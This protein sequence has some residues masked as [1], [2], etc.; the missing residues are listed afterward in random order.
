MESGQPSLQKSHR[1]IFTGDI[2]FPKDGGH[3]SFTVRYRTEPNTQW[4]WVNEQFG[5]RDGELVFEPPQREIERCL[6]MKE[7]ASQLAQFISD[8]NPDLRV[9]SCTSESPGAVVWKVTG[10]V[11]PVAANKSSIKNVALGKP[12]EFVRNFSLV[13]IWNPWL[14]PRHGGATYRLT[15]DALLSSFLLKDGKHLVI[16]AISINDVLTL[17]QSGG[18]NDIVISAKNDSKAE[19]SFQI[20]AS[21]A[22]SFDVGNAAV[23]YEARRVVSQFAHPASQGNSESSAPSSPLGNDIVVVEDIPKAQWLSNWYDGLAYCTWNSLG[24]DLSEEKLLNALDTLKKNGIKIVNLIID[25]NWQSLDNKGQSQFKRGWTGFEA[26]KEGFPNGLKHAIEKI[27]KNHANIEHIAVWHALLGYWGGI[28]PD[29]QIAKDY[30]TKRVKKVDG[31]AG[32]TMTAI[33]PDDIHRFYDDFYSFL[34]SAGIDSVKADAQFFLD[35][36]EDPEDRVRFTAA[37]QDAWTIS[38][39]RHFQTKAISCMSQAP[40]I[41]F[42]SQIP[43]NKPQILLRNSDDFF[44]DIPSSHPWHIFCNAHNALFTQHL[45]VLPDWDMFQTSHPYASF[46]GAARCISGG[47]VYITDEPGK[48]DIDLINQMTAPTVKGNSIILRPSVVGRAMNMYHNYNEGQMLK[49]GSFNGWARTGSGI[50]GLF[51]IN[52]S[53]VSSLIP[54]IDFPGISAGTGDEYVVR[55]HKTGKVSRNLDSSAGDSLI[56][57]FLATKGWEI[58]TAYPLRSF[59]LAGSHGIDYGETNSLTRVAVLGLL[60]KMTGVAA[61]TSSDIFVKDNGR[62]QFDISL[63]ALG[64]LG[65][66][67]SDLDERSIE[68]NFLVTILGSVVPFH[69]VRKASNAIEAGAPAGL[70]EIDILAAWSEMGL[71]SGWSNE[72]VVQVFMS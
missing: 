44:P 19:Q 7:H 25:D 62:L 36:L 13:R 59:T 33:D 69:T 37:Y 38:T 57:I 4:Q 58:L 55:S 21:V 3:Y 66:Y 41:I 16:L 28:S 2:K 24:Q 9:D 71:D 47:P 46:H 14:A 31:V 6:E 53:D 30:K 54:L 52:T 51:N 49:V 22:S 35:L 10:Q 15:E 60:G 72:V 65:I 8:L 5:T 29:G 34:L 1:Y 68:N 43:T 56:S 64:V 26:N 32:G 27:R 50:L 23:I 42:H 39:L 61:I 40:Q 17:L 11:G 70:L 48:H 18:N 20:I 12:R 63:K 67:V 45:S